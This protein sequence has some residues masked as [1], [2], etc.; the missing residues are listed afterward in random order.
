MNR[1]SCSVSIINER[2]RMYKRI[3][4]IAIAIALPLA[5]SASPGDK[6]DFTGRHGNRV[7]FMTKE[8]G[9]SPEQKTKLETIF[10]ENKEKFKALHEEKQKLIEGILTKDQLEKYAELK[11]Q[12]H[13]KW[14]KYHQDSSN[15]SSP[16]QPK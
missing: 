2:L 15:G 13:E 11:K 16:T 9:L 8:L 3:I 10:N 7:E 1:R 5:V 4:T 12:R 6:G 14:Q